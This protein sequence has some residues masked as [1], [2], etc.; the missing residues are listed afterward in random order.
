MRLNAPDTQPQKDMRDRA[1]PVV[2]IGCGF[3]RAEAASL[4]VSHI[5]QRDGRWTISDSTE[6]VQA[7][8]DRRRS[9]NFRTSEKEQAEAII[10]TDRSEPG[11]FKK[12]SPVTEEKKVFAKV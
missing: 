4:A 11:C 9:N 7:E 2:L 1:V 12:L 8:N 3:R 6:S 10:H 5:E